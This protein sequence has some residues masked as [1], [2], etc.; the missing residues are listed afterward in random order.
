MLKGKQGMQK[1]FKTNSPDNNN[2]KALNRLASFFITQY[3]K[4]RFAQESLSVLG[5]NIPKGVSMLRNGTC[6][7]L[8]I[9]HENPHRN[10]AKNKLLNP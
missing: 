6:F 3:E 8:K 1:R 2:D 4:V 9:E 7:K 10:N 5:K